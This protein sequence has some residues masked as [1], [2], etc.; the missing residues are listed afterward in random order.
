M[1]GC[2]SLEVESVW[3]SER[4][5]SGGGVGGFDGGCMLLLGLLTCSWL[6]L[7]DSCLLILL[8]LGF[9][10]RLLFSSHA[11]GWVRSLRVSEDSSMYARFSPKKS[12][13]LQPGEEVAGGRSGRRP[14]GEGGKRGTD[15]KQHSETGVSLLSSF[16]TNPRSSFG[17]SL[18]VC[19]FVVTSVS[20]DVSNSVLLTTR[21]GWNLSTEKDEDTEDLSDLES[22]GD[23]DPERN[24]S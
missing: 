16:I 9:R 5:E 2:Q 3:E 17:N 10:G 24:P 15:S 8:L 1:S 21:Q 14:G 20:L 13:S 19:C 23:S 22:N 7:C 6:H 18:S 12:S 4:E 11:A